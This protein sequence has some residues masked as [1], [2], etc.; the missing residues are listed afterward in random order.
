MLHEKITL[1]LLWHSF[2][3]CSVLFSREILQLLACISLVTW[4]WERRNGSVGVGVE[5]PINFIQT[6]IVVSWAEARVKL[7]PFVSIDDS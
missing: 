2:C 3:D 1:V 6:H 4:S 5:I 7:V